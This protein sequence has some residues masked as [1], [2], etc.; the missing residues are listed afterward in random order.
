[1][2]VAILTA[3]AL[4]HRAFASLACNSTRLDV[5]AVFYEQTRTLNELVSFDP[6]ADL[7]RQHLAAR[8]Q[9]EQDFFALYLECQ[10][11]TAKFSKGVPRGWFSTPEF[12]EELKSLRIDLILVYGTSKIKGNVI[13]LYEKRMLN[14]HL[15]L[16]PYYRGSG[17]NYFPFV[18]REPEYCGATYMFL[19]S[20]VDTGV[21]IHQI[22]PLILK[23]D[24][25]HQLSNRFLLRVFKAYI[26]IA[27]AF[28]QLE[29]PPGIFP[30]QEH[31]TTRRVYR[32]I[33]FTR[34]SVETLY[35]NFSTGMI[36]EYLDNLQIRN[37]NVPLVQH[38]SLIGLA[39]I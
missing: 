39:D 34:K 25:F 17:T 20:G 2:N 5:T 26:L 6:T 8:D 36:N 23:T 4:R 32:D 18:N 1:V 27:A 24:S 30:T 28:E 33:D 35:S 14:V 38:K 29:S 11:Q 37:A 16:S 22:R 31:S 10:L 15:G 3:N 12:I 9:A 19:D 21:I 13:K 7:E